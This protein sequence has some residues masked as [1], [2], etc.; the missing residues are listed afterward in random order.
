MQIAPNPAA[1][2]SLRS[3]TGGDPKVVRVRRD[4]DNSEKDFTASDVTSGELTRYVNAAAI[5][6]LD[7][8][9]LQSDGRTGDFIIAKAA[10]SLRS[11]GDRQATIA[12]DAA[13]LNED[14]VVPASG[15]YVVQVRR[16]VDGTIKSF[17][18][19]EVSD[20]TLASFVNESFTSSLP[21]DVQGSAAAAYSLRNLSSTYSGAV[22]NVRR[23]SDDTTK[24]FTADSITNGDLVAFCSSV[25]LTQ[26]YTTTS[27]SE[28]SADFIDRSNFTLTYTDLPSAGT[29]RFFN[30]KNKLNNNNF[31]KGKYTATFTATV[32]GN[33]TVGVS[34]DGSSMTGNATFSSSDGTASH[35][36]TA[37][38]TSSD[39]GNFY[40]KLKSDTGSDESGTVVIT[41]FNLQQVF[42]DGHVTTWYDQ[43]GN[44]NNATQGTAGSQPKIVSAGSLL[45]DGVDFDGTDDELETAASISGSN[46]SGFV[47]ANLDGTAANSLYSVGNTKPN[48]LF[49]NPSLA[50]S[51][52]GGAALSGGT[53]PTNTDTLFTQL[54]ISGGTS[55]TFIDGSAIAS[56]D[57]GSNTASSDK[58]TIGNL[59]SGDRFMDG[60]IKELIIYTSDQTE[61]LRSIEES[62]SGNYSG[63][64]LASFSRDGMVRTWYDQ[65]VT[66]QGGATGNA[67]HAI[68][69]TAANQPT[70]VSNGSLV[71]DNGID[72]D[73]SSENFLVATSVSG[74][75]EK[76]SLFATSVRDSTGYIVSLSNSSNSSKYFAVQEAASTSDVVP[77]NT[78]FGA[79]AQPSVSGNTRL[80]FGLTTGDT[81]TSGGALGGALTTNTS[82]YG[83]DF[84]S[85]DLD[86]IAI[87]TLRT[88]SPSSAHFFEGRI[89]EILVYASSATGDQTD[90]RGAFEANIASH[91]GITAIPTAADPPTVNG[92]V[93][94]WYD[95][96]GNGN[97][98]VQ[99]TATKQPKIV[100]SG[101]L[102]TDGILFGAN[103]NLPLSGT[104]LDILKNVTHG[105]IFSV[106]KPLVTGTGN[107]RYFGA[108]IN[109][110]TVARFLFAD[111]QATNASVR[112]GGRSLDGDSFTDLE[113]TT[114]HS[115]AVSVLTGFI[116][117]GTKT[118][119]LF[120]NGSQ[121]N[122]STLANM[123][124]GNT[125]NT[126][127]DTVAI[128]DFVS[129]GSNTSDFNAKEIILFNTD[130]SANRSAIE[131]NINNHYSI[132]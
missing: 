81:V 96:S 82:D 98:A 36:F 18:A 73:D 20:G 84:G 55:K 16:N 51:L 79:S 22:V 19:D 91:F 42:C 54:F 35:T 77:R 99:A 94:T 78:A 37:T 122:T 100:N 124:A 120:L 83:N 38:S 32:T 71:A 68:Q 3:L 39:A 119:T 5:K 131:S 65:S 21:L 33:A 15:K 69:A 70:I 40:F 60:S 85:G 126:S 107:G 90:N 80:T 34:R 67:H 104:G 111:S 1:A 87:G 25:D 118:A 113:G 93:E 129:S 41:N 43:S 46:I 29:N 8:Q 115:N 47:V 26:T 109:G 23:S 128:G 10:Y 9:A 12:N 50:Y 110:G 28:I 48:V 61:K 24:D 6:P 31:G 7:V 56:G 116:N 130:Q 114:T 17:T 101:S 132:F 57:A 2:Y 76:L 30:I 88:V 59:E 53:A 121:I 112:I 103:I 102:L 66:D 63:I 106:L 97:D 117:Y 74:M 108:S 105:N 49:G 127:S 52:N 95:Q 72:F 13:P 27:S 58:L 64:T 86:Q 75:E 89:R 125:S 92:F 11:L 62:V 44:S 45:A 14:T 123:T 4:S